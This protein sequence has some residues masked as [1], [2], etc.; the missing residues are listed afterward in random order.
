MRD[1][2]GG[3]PMRHAVG[4]YGSDEEFVGTFAPVCQDA[5]ERDEP[6]IVRLEERK[7]DLLR[8]ALEDPGGVLFL[9]PGEQY[10]HPPRA[11]EATL[12]LVDRHAGAGGKA[13]CLLGELPSLTGLSRDAW[14]RYEATVNHVLRGRPVRP[15]CACDTRATP[16]AARADLLRTHDTV[17]TAGGRHQP[18]ER[19]EDPESFLAK[20]DQEG[21]R[22]P[23]QTDP[24]EVELRNPS[25]SSARQ[26]VK[27]LA[28][29]ARLDPTMS[30]NLMLGVSEVLANAILHGR[31]PVRM[32]AWQGP[33]RVMVA[34]Q[35]LGGGP[36]DPFVGLLPVE[37]GAREGGLGLWITHQLCPEI[38]LSTTED[39]FTV[40]L[41]AGAGS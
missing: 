7:S 18:N 35:D 25:P 15:V 28:A 3:A 20:R 16:E 11:L 19:F 38:A 8:S 24:P 2:R 29:A 14:T 30:E 23:L 1:Q 40:R 10:A 6:M 27:K 26:A 4:F 41:A 17:V 5:L 36:S 39:G 13:L 34:V 32:T 12:D 37:P 22:D 9:D 31:A 21:I 33:G